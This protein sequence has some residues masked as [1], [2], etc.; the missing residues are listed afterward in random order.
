M[1]PT[2]TITADIINQHLPMKTAID[3]VEEAFKDFVSGDAFMP[4]KQY[5]D[6]PQYNGDFRAMPA[7]S[8][9]Y[10][11][12]GIKWVNS[13]ANSPKD[14]PSVMATL[15]LNNPKTG[16]PLAIV[17]GTLLTCIRTGAAG[18]IA[19]KYLAKASA[20]SLAL[21]GC[22][23]Q[24]Y[25]QAEAIC[26]VRS[27]DTIYLYDL[28][29]TK[30]F[31]SKIKSF[32]SATIIS[33]NTV[34]EATQQA[35]VVVTTTPSKTPVVM[36][37][38]IKPG[39]HINAIGADA[40]GKQEVETALLLKSKIIIDDWVQASH[41]GEINIPVHQNALTQGDIAAELGD[42]IANNVTVRTSDSD[43][44]LFDS[45]GLA[46]QDIVAAGYIYRQL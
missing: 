15:L 36:L 40:E 45:T 35:D 17:D 10:D 25:Y 21:V 3:V 19:T 7:F 27:I 22:G 28:Q 43:I 23:I 30:A 42:V 29:D 24:A 33:C 1:I 20:S 34:S 26:L 46:I 13:H 38:D 32:T 11:V 37:N 12:A 44:T 14:I 2:V 5:L 8:N 39:T 41:S 9:R 16:V 4:P 6:L 18:G 31:E